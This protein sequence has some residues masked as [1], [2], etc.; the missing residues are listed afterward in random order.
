ME[1]NKGQV[2]TEAQLSQIA[3]RL[4]VTMD[5]DSKLAL[6]KEECIEFIC[7]IKE[8]LYHD[9][10]IYDKDKAAIEAMYETLPKVE[11]EIEIVVNPLN[12]NKKRK[13]I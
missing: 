12:P 10:Y 6:S 1:S 11:M 13:E 8:H 2:V 5:A 4:F 9:E 7:F 3:R